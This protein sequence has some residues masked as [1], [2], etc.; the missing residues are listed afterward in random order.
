M[1]T[2]HIACS[3]VIENSDDMLDNTNFIMALR[4]TDGG[5]SA[6]PVWS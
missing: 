6:A 1:R 2:R 5:S 3:S 4:L